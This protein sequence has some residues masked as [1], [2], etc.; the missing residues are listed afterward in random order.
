MGCGRKPLRTRQ[1]KMLLPQDVR[2]WPTLDEYDTA[3]KKPLIT[4]YDTDVKVGEL[5]VD[6]RPLRLIANSS[7]YVTV[8]KMSD[9]VVRCFFTN[10]ISNTQ[11][12]SPPP[13]IRE[14]YLQINN[15]MR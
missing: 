13:D 15:Y 3:L 10:V 1:V 6:S 4:V 8:Y 12:V 2:I 9:W 14:R 7:K 5:P 11:I